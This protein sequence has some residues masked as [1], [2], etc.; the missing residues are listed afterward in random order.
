MKT[1]TWVGLCIMYHGLSERPIQFK[2]SWKSG[3]INIIR[4]FFFGLLKRESCEQRLDV[5][6]VSWEIEHFWNSISKSGATEQWFIT[7]LQMIPWHRWR[8]EL[9]ND[10]SSFSFFFSE[11]SLPKLQI[12]IKIETYPD[13]PEYFFSH[14]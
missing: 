4:S 5:Y 14:F 3:G 13:L 9:K 7:R 10:N 2:L 1:Y 11:F 12:N 8:Y 6:W